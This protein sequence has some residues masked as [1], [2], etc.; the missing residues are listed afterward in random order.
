MNSNDVL[1]L[2]DKARYNPGAMFE[3]GVDMLE[4]ANGGEL[5]FVDASQPAVQLI[6]MAATLAASAMHESAANTRR[7]FA[8]MALDEEELY[9]HMS[10]KDY[11][12]RW[13]TPSRTTITVAMAME[14]VLAR[15][16]PTGVNGVQKMVIPRN[17]EF[18]VAGVTFSMQYPIEIRINSAGTERVVYDVSRPSPL[19]PLS[20]NLLKT[21]KSS[22]AGGIE[23]LF[24]EIPVMQMKVSSN[25]FVVSKASPTSGAITFGGSYYA[26]RAYHRN[27]D[28][29]WEEILTTETRQVFDPAQPT[30]ALQV[31]SD[32]VM[33]S[34]PEVYATAGTIKKQLRLDVYSTEGELSMILSNYESDAFDYRWQDFDND[35]N[36]LYW[37]A[38]E[39]I[40]TLLVFSDE[41]VTGGSGAKSFEV[42][43]EQVMMNAHGASNQP[44][45]PWQI[46]STLTNEGY[47]SVKTVD[48]LT[49]R[50]YK[51]SRP[52]PLPEDGSV[53]SPIGAGIMTFQ[54]SLEGLKGYEGVYD[55]GERVT[56]SPKMLYKL[57]NG[58]VKIVEKD[59]LNM[60]NGA[61]LETRARLIN[62]E[63]YLFSPYHY[64]LDITGNVF[65]TR[66]YYLDNPSIDSRN[67]IAENDTLGMTISTESFDIERTE[68]GYRIT[69]VTASSEEALALPD[70][71]VHAQLSFQPT[72][73]SG[74]AYLNGVLDVKLASGERAY[75]FELESNLDINSNDDLYLTNFQMFGGSTRPVPASLTE[76]FDLFYVLSDYRPVDTLTTDIDLIIAKEMLP[77]DA[78]ALTHEKFNTNLG[79]SLD[80][81]WSASR[82]VVSEE[83]YKRY[84]ADVSWVYEEPE[85]A[86]DPATGTI[87]YDIVNG[88]MKYRMLHAKGEVRLDDDGKPMIRFLKGDVM[89]DADG[90]PM[91]E[92]TRKM[93]RQVDLFFLDGKYWFA[94]NPVSVA[95]RDSTAQTV[96]RWLTTDIATIRAK[97]LEGTELYFAPQ[98]TL[99]NVQ[100]FVEE[101]LISNIPAEQGL[102]VGLYLGRAEYADARLRESLTR[103]IKLV[104]ADRLIQSTV[105]ID[106]ITDKLREEI[107]N[108]AIAFSVSGLGGANNF[109]VITA[110]D[111]TL[112]CSVRKRVVAK[113]DDT[114]VVE[115]DVQIDPLRHTL[116][117]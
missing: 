103:S 109:P 60:I 101:G 72:G 13:A 6:E 97:L 108:E 98:T 87:L 91:V 43:R 78:I 105:A 55:N 22:Q 71:S 88:E 115:D 10:D 111:D 38:L 3:V 15:A 80:G 90:N 76:S 28:G 114:L 93:Q 1:V 21:W 100:V 45:T 77:E 107:G 51:T 8:R 112:R 52:L 27:G 30:V 85:F 54:Q 24:I 75:V 89:R 46:I 56:L 84:S 92:S 86:R 12:G 17:T 113:S 94:T 95:Y 37:A 20:T 117:K 41:V 34:V 104:I 31:Y 68:K 26:T 16:V 81:L 57:D 23:M 59:E 44:I 29:P 106:D 48:N 42:L 63:R 32:R 7:Q 83:D 50:I 66:G 18:T 5:I 62:A 82:S 25:N 64:V 4:Q 19:M 53:L 40:S 47:S 116:A 35:D 11:I 65:D 73:E 67:F 99:G 74:R 36:G 33:Y 102:R 79:S 96:V 69:V 39:N 2:L 9:L 14:E 61:I 58:L 49:R 70:S 110:M